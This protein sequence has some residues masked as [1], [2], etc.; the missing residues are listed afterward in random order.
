[1]H[2]TDAPQ[3]GKG[4]LTTAAEAKGLRVNSLALL[5]WGSIFV[6]VV[7]S[8][9]F[10]AWSYQSIMR[11]AEATA[12]SQARLVSEYALRLVDTQMTMLRA[13]ELQLALGLIGDVGDLEMHQFLAALD[14]TQSASHGIA[15]ISLEGRMVAS[16]ANFPVDV[17][18]G[19]RDYL[20]A[21]RAGVDPFIDRIV[22]QP[23]RQD[24]FIVS[25]RVE[26]PQF[27]GLVISSLTITAIRE[28]LLQIAGNQ[29]NAAAIIRDDGQLL[30]RSSPIRSITLP[31]DHPGRI[32]MQRGPSGTYTTRSVADGRVRTYAF[33]KVSGLPIF[34]HFGVSTEATMKTWL[35]QVLLVSLLM[36]ALGA[37]GYSAVLG[38][39]RNLATRTLRLRAASERQKRREAEALAELRRTMMLELNHRVKNNLHLITTMIGIQMREKGMVEPAELNARIHAISEVHDLLYRSGDGAHAD[40][41]VFLKEVCA[42]AAILPPEHRI[43]V[44]CQV[45]EGV[46]I[47]ADR[48][49]PIAL[50]AVELITNAV[51][52][53]FNGHDAPRLVIQLRRRNEEIEL[54][55]ADNGPG[56]PAETTR[57][58]GLRMVHAFVRQA[59]GKLEQFNDGGAHF[60]IVLPAD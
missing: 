57:S 29:G 33:A 58:S 8:L 39:E 31:L 30:V 3:S 13:V 41:G 24:A 35:R 42:N 46:A 56:M 16:S 32:G 1:M 38:A 60:R 22:L 7:A 28:F 5:R 34:A 6:P 14:G 44:D 40:F 19:Q 20:D 50:A 51:K 37:A 47:Q 11:E 25:R 26:T 59:S 49:T 4:V 43:D 18:M 48:V 54:Q 2:A 23:G 36:I 53:A 9:V 27:D 10:A 45:D 52:Y 17:E 21:A 55:I 12:R 15:A